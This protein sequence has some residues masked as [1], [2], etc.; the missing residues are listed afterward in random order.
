[1]T[2]RLKDVPDHH[3]AEIVMR[4]Y[5]LRREP[6][7]RESRAALS[8]DYW[9]TNVDEA[10]APTQ[11]GHPLNVAYRQCTSYWEMAYSM[12]KNGVLHGDFMLD[13]AGGEGLFLFARV[14]PHLAGMR[15]RLHPGVFRNVEW[16]SN[17]SELSRQMQARFDHLYQV[18]LQARAKG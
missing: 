10:M 4:L 1:M 8:R 14:K 12:V 17:H 3:D 13:A 15:E 9:P 7:M 16:M 11:G 18:A 6:V 5:E 2:M